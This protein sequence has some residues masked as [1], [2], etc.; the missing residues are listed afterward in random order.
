M[1][2]IP[3]DQPPAILVQIAVFADGKIRYAGQFPAD[4]VVLRGLLDKAKDDL[5]AQLR[6]QAQGGG[7]EVPPPGLV[8]RLNGFNGKG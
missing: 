7:I 5:I 8:N 1:D 2:Q 4:E 3:V 6:K